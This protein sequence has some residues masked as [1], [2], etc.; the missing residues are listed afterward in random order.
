MMSLRYSFFI[1]L[2]LSPWGAWSEAICSV[3][4]EGKEV[5]A[6]DE[7]FTFPNQPSVACLVVEQAGKNGKIPKSQCPLLA[8]LLF[9][10]CKC[11]PIN[12]SSLMPVVTTSTPS[13]PVISPTAVT[14]G[15]VITMLPSITPVLS[16]STTYPTVILDT[17]SPS[18]LSPV[19]AVPITRPP[20]FPVITPSTIYPTVGT[21]SPSVKPA[22]LTLAP[23]ANGPDLAPEMIPTIYPIVTF[24]PELIPTK[25]PI[26]TFAP[27][28]L[29]TNY[30]IFTFDPAIIPEEIRS[31]VVPPS[32]KMFAP[33]VSDHV[34][35]KAGFEPKDKFFRIKD[36]EKSKGKEPEFG[37]MGPKG[38]KSSTF[39]PA[40][41]GFPIPSDKGTKSEKDL[42]EEKSGKDKE[43]GVISKA[44]DKGTNVAIASD[45]TSPLMSLGVSVE[46]VDIAPTDKGLE[47]KGGK[48]SKVKGMETSTK[49]QKDGFGFMMMGHTKLAKGEGGSHGIVT[50][51][52]AEPSRV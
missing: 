50:R 7:F 4:G 6:P 48:E 15:P 32:D 36:G 14:M 29:P 10:A 19:T 43:S 20:V 8:P 40:P 27:D 2:A 22:P 38:K 34:S 3:C 1:F 52:L 47:G 5:K 46:S 49:T 26:F 17:S 30:P 21:S 28:I 24:V 35:G 23:V 31:Q 39:S 45:L 37:G 41:T 33:V 13:A 11:G 9:E 44:E 16:P 42:K 25:H 51:R 18:S 12:E